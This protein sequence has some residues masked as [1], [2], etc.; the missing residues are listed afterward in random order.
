MM[1]NIAVRAPIISFCLFYAMAHFSPLHLYLYLF[2]EWGF[3]L[4]LNIMCDVVHNSVK[5]NCFDL[6]RFDPCNENLNAF[7]I[8]IQAWITTRPPLYSS[9]VNTCAL[10][11]GQ[12][13]WKQTTSGPSGSVWF[14]HNLITQ[15][16][17][18]AKSKI[19]FKLWSF[20][21]STEEEI[22]A[23]LLLSN[24][25]VK[26]LSL[27]GPQQCIADIRERLLFSFEHME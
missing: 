11:V 6:S 21:L 15:F 23:T 5:L 7:V 14:H 17:G 18:K 13:V 1:W 9:A 12:Y 19:Q 4:T 8:L 2:V 26:K 3:L 22:C 10:N 16:P 24:N 25:A 27:L 20:V